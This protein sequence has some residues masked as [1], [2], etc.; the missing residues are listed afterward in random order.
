MLLDWLVRRFCLYICDQSSA[1]QE[2]RIAGLM[3]QKEGSVGRELQ[4]CLRIYT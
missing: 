2:I 3:I 1:R 4:Y